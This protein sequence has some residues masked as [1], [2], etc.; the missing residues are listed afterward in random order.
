MQH[1]ITLQHPR[2]LILRGTAISSQHCLVPILAHPRISLSLIAPV[3]RPKEIPRS[4]P[5]S[6]FRQDTSPVPSTGRDDPPMGAA[7]GGIARPVARC[8]PLITAVPVTAAPPGP[9]RPVAGSPLL[10]LKAVPLLVPRS[11][12]HSKPRV[13]PVSPPTSC[14]FFPKVSRCS[15]PQWRCSVIVLTTDRICPCLPALMGSGISNGL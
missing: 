15:L 2:M 9:R 10:G 6:S 3:V 12:S 1:G 4:G 5:V 13:S 14:A 8:G 7:S 11:L